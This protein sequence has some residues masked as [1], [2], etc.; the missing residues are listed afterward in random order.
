MHPVL[1]L[2]ND[3]WPVLT[4]VRSLPPAKFVFSESGR[5]GIATDSLVAEGKGAGEP[6]RNGRRREDAVIRGHHS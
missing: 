1:N 6:G 3:R 2:Y 4:W 5:M